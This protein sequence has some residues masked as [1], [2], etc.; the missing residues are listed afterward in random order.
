MC[1]KT[2]NAT[3]K[4]EHRYNRGRTNVAQETVRKNS[5][6]KLAWSLGSISK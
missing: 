1:M 2:G 3:A 5:E 4:F 6:E